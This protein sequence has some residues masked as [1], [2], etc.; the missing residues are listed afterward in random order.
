MGVDLVGEVS[1]AGEQLSQ[2]QC[3]LCKYEDLRQT[4]QPM[5]LVLFV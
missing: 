5:V 2:L 4:P 1:E 3:F